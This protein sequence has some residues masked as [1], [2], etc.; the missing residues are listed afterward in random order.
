MATCPGCGRWFNK[1]QTCLD[2]INK[3]H[4]QQLD[5][6]GYDAAQWLYASTHN[7]SIEGFCQCGCGKRTAWNYK[8]GKPYRV[9]TD[10]EC[11]KRLYAQA[12][13]NMQ[14]ARGTSVHSLLHD[15]E[16]Q[17][18]M[19]EHRP[20]H[21][22]YKFSTGGE[23]DYLSKLELNFLKFCDLVMEFTANMFAPCPETF[24]YYD[25]E[26]NTTRQYMPDFYLPDYNLIVE[27]KD[28]G[29]KHNTNPAFL[30]ETRYKT[31]LKD[32]VMRNQR[33]Y[34]YIR[35]SGANYGP[36]VE[37]LYK[38]VHEDQDDKPVDRKKKYVIITE[39]AGMKLAPKEEKRYY[40]FVGYDPDVRMSSFIALTDDFLY[41]HGYNIATG[42]MGAYT[43]QDPEM[44]NQ[45][46]MCYRYIGYHPED[47]ESLLADLQ[48]HIA[49]NTPFEDGFMGL[50]S[51]H[52]ILFDDG[53]GIVA[54]NPHR[55][56]MFSPVQLII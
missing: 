38:I 6:S 47:M 23:V 16:H 39:S 15:M 7:G 40:L 21:G 8:T 20:T 27:I 34:N 4:A 5:Q 2:H 12:E 3:Y 22:Y 53:L 11:K 10:P 49:T 55:A 14:K 19:Q 29:K 9:S 48:S 50:L 54:N 33:K 30:K 13:H 32:E 56:S 51:N 28:G 24:E 36:F 1:K 52:N 37:L 43:A 35:I 44:K 46:R 42:A 31:E 45:L 17:K 41:W 18:S 25:P 26:T